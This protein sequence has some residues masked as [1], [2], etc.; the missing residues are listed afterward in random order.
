MTYQQ[1]LD[2]L[3]SQLPMYQRIGPAAYK[4]NLDNTLALSRYFKQPEN[5]FKSI[6]V[7][8]TNGKG[9]VSHMISSVLQ[10]AGYKTGL[11]TSPHLKDFRE[12]IKINGRPVPKSYVRDFVSMHRTFFET[13]QPSFF[14]MTMAM[15]FC[16]FAEQQ[17]DVAVVETGL[18]GRLDSSNI[19]HPELSIITNIGW[20]HVKLLGPGLPDIAREKAGIIKD[21][22]PVVIGKRQPELLHIFEERA[23][24]CNAPLYMADEIFSLCGHTHIDKGNYHAMKVDFETGGVALTY[25]TDLTGS[26]QTEN[27]LTALSAL[28][29]LQTEKKWE[30]SS[31]SISQGLERVV[32]NTGLAGRWQ[33]IGRKPE[34]IC[35]TAHNADGLSLVLKQLM[36]IPH[37]RLHIVLGMVDDKDI[38]SV[39]GL[40]PREATYYFCKPSVPR[41]LNAKELAMA[42][43]SLDL[44]GKSYMDVSD[45][46]VSAKKAASANDLIFVGGST[47]VVAEVI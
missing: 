28:K 13:L 38:A 10:Q 16:W 18:G 39:L 34:I 46:L 14:E 42:A 40:F 43:S 6:H 5:T 47:F 9:S 1:T 24:L 23:R 26:Y 32:A 20:D 4:A 2:Y 30:I 33:R 36:A 44:I 22:V 35:D 11:A 15:T 45:A 12:R 41:G 3:F 27:L 21:G 31:Q 19:I 8:G 7:A 17:V 29:I 37:A 25:L